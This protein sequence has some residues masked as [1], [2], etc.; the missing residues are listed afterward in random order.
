MSA[1]WTLDAMAAAMNAE[2]AGALPTELSGISI[3]SRTLAKGEAFFAIQGEN[4]DGHDFVDNA[5][6][7]GA[8]FA[9]VARSQRGRFPNAPL[10]VVPDVLEALRQLGRA[11]RVRSHA[12]VVAVTGSVGKTG[13]KEALRL[14]LSADANLRNGLNVHDG[15]VTYRAVADA[16]KLPYTHADHALRI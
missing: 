16:L 11:A 12:K 15:H 9:V 7:G 1:L 13:T 4:R 5:L 2:R 8:G 10:L 14:A 6:K 3:D